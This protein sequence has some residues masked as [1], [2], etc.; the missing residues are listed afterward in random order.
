MLLAFEIEIANSYY[1]KWRNNP[2]IIGNN[3]KSSSS[4]LLFSHDEKNSDWFLF[5]FFT[6]FIIQL[7]GDR[8]QAISHIIPIEIYLHAVDQCEL[9]FKKYLAF[10]LQYLLCTVPGSFHKSL[11]IVLVQLTILSSILLPSRV[12]YLLKV[13]PEEQMR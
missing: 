10:L 13:C 2:T 1:L 9:N 6:H 4:F 7:F 12:L 8:P 3:S 11:R 5:A